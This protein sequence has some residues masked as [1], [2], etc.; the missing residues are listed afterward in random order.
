MMAPNEEIG[1]RSDENITPAVALG[2][3]R[4]Y[5]ATSSAS[6]STAGQWIT[7]I[8]FND[9]ISFYSKP[10]V[11]KNCAEEVARRLTRVTD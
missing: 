10:L 2:I 6:A 11:S 3:A 4:L 7:H 5:G 1:A 9:R 8:N